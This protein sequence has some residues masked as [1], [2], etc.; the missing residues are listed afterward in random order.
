MTVSMPPLALPINSEATETIAEPGGSK[1]IQTRL[2]KAP[3][4]RVWAAWIEPAQLGQWW[5]PKGFSVTTD[6]FE[7]RVGGHWIFT[8]HGP[9]PDPNSKN[10]GDPRD[11]PNH[12]VWTRIECSA[13]ACD[14]SP[15]PGPWYLEFH[16]VHA[17]RIDSTF[18]KTAIT[19]EERDGHTLLSWHAD[20]GSNEIR[21]QVIRDYGAAIG[22]RE[23]TA[24]LANHTETDAF[25][26]TSAAQAYRLYLSRILPVRRELVWRAWTEPDLLKQWFCPKPYG[27][28]RCELDLRAGGRF[29]THMFGPNDWQN[30]NDGSYLEVIPRQRLTFTDLLL[31]DW[32]PALKPGLGFTATVIFEDAGEGKTKYTAIA[33][34]ANAQGR[35]THAR[36]GFHDGWGTATDQLVEFVSTL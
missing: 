19:F 7:F 20:F 28:D 17:D 5:G 32:V 21:D 2:I 13:S 9:D 16:H 8:M 12:I 25:A 4:E 26:Q 24:R 31:A 3:R 15:A 34:H 1:I 29:Y 35:A 36:M 10:A 27:V 14:A 18:F 33:R 22:G 30:D 6:V 11:F 23:T